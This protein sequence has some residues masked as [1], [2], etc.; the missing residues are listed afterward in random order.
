MIDDNIPPHLLKRT[1]K[2]WAT[3]FLL[4]SRR[5]I[6]TTWRCLIFFVNHFFLPYWQ[7]LRDY[8]HYIGLSF[9]KKKSATLITTKRGLYPLIKN[10]N[11][12]EMKMKPV[13]F[14]NFQ[15]HS[16][17]TQ[18]IFDRSP[19]EVKHLEIR[20]IMVLICI[21]IERIQQTLRVSYSPQLNL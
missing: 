10:T 1:K 6:I 17:S 7:I 3:F 5:N 14:S 13:G 11:E 21:F 15:F 20:V 19:I 4:F 2:R 16:S 12:N 18:E 8:S 9:K